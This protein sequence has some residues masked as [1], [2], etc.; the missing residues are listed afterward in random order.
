[1][2][3]VRNTMKKERLV[4]TSPGSSGGLPEKR[5]EREEER[6]ESVPPR[7]CGST[8]ARPGSSMVA[9]GELDM[10]VG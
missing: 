2:T 10:G 7:Q 4:R 5:E 8:V 1:M 9:G 6:R 3:S